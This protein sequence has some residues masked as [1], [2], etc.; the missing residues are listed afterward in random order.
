MPRKHDELYWLT[1]NRHGVYCA[2]WYDE[3]TRQTRQRSLGTTDLRAAQAELIQFQATHYRPR[4][5]EPEDVELTQIW[6][7]Y[8]DE[9]GSKRPT[10]AD[11]LHAHLTRLGEWWAGRAVADLTHD[12]QKQFRDAMIGGWGRWKPCAPGYAQRILHT[13]RAALNHAYKAGRLRTVPH[14]KVPDPA[15]P[16]DWGLSQEL[17]NAERLD[18]VATPQEIRRFLEA[19]RGDPQRA[20]IE[21]VLWLLLSCVRP[22]A[23]LQLRWEQ[24]DLRA[25]V[26]DTRGNREETKKRR[27]KLPIPTAAR[28]HLMTLSRAP[29]PTEVLERFKIDEARATCVVRRA[30]QHAGRDVLLPI[31]TVKRGWAAARS[32]AELPRE[33][34]PR[35]FRHFA[36][37]RMAAAGVPL[38]QVDYMLGHAI[39]STTKRYVHLSPDH[40]REARDALDEWHSV[41]VGEASGGASREEK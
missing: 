16:S 35:M 20:H 13:M 32:L 6:L 27:A 12:R 38:L 8:W 30:T 18:Y 23:L 25:R 17:E 40:L 11:S 36:G 26:M 7:W 19:V 15:K 37:T 24:I 10:G 34:T 5:A 1:R 22:E 29:T 39:P 4:D 9:H 21:T 33:F 41:I 31:T 3:D 28:D 2:T 14:I